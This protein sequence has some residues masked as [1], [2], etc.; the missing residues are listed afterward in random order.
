LPG[1][2][3][4]I[5][6]L[7]LPDPRIAGVAFTGSTAVAQHIN[8]TLAAR[9]GAIVPLIAETGGLN[10]MLVDSSALP[11]QVVDDVVASSFLSAGQRCSSLRVLCLQEEI[12]GA[13]L[14][15]LAGAMRTLSIGDPAS[16]ATD[17]GPV[18]D[19]TAQATLEQHV[20][21]MREVGRIV[22]RCNLPAGLRGTF[23]PPTAIEIDSIDRLKGEVFGPV[24]HVVR[25]ASAEVDDLLARI[26]ATGY[27]LTLGV[28]SR[29]D[30]FTRDVYGASIAG[31]VYVNRDMVGA[32]VGVN[33]FGGQGLSGTG[34]KA[35]SPH[36]LFRY[37]TERTFTENLTAK[38]G[39]TEL[40]SRA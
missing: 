36:T 3:A 17:I 34:P 32:V 12:A 16:L 21:T 26:R 40:W 31:N 28:H 27:G 4:R 11:E 1:D 15:M 23:F 22:A 39:N 14:D 10:A 38:G 2:G 6:E 9:S 24:L 29:I 35:G 7:L 33:P 5:G 13:V 19:T 18:I 8:R 30:G 25:Y 37:A 20:A